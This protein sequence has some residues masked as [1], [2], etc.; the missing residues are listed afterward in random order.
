MIKEGTPPHPVY[1]P[2]GSGL[3]GIYKDRQRDC[4]YTYYGWMGVAREDTETRKALAQE[5][6]Q[7]F[8]APHAAFISMPETM[9]RA[10][11]IDLGIFIQSIMLLFAENG[12]ACIPQGALAS[13]PEPVKE[14]VFIPEGNAIMVGLSFGYE[15]K[16]AR[17]NKLRM[18]RAELDEIFS[19]AG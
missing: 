14:V 16:A 18:S 9:H 17:V 2:G 11:T 19:F 8:G 3:K 10:N 6:W 4:G 7:F 15:D 1:P 12:I 13:Y 5:N